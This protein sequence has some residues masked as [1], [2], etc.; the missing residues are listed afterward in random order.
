MEYALEVNNLWKEYEQF[1]L[2]S[3]DFKLEPGYIMGLIGPNG[4]GKTTLMRTILGIYEQNQ[5]EIKIF[6]KSLKDA[7]AQKDAKEMVGFV[8]EDNPFIEEFSCL[9]NGKIFG[10]YYLNWDQELFRS[11]LKRFEVDGKKKLSRLSK[12]MKIKFQLAFALSHNIKLLVMDEPSSGLDPVFRKELMEI[13]YDLIME[14]ER[15]ILFSTHLTEELDK[16]ADYITFLNQGKQ[17]FSMSKEEIAQRYR[18]V[19]GSETA[20]NSLNGADIIGKRKGAY[21]SEALVNYNIKEDYSKLQTEE[22]DIEDI[23]YYISEQGRG[24][25]NV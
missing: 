7:R 12:G 11:Y 1:Q 21:Y 3:V 25:R 9:E 20:V 23:M 18:L 19:K 2:E 17:I 5:G 15:S 6:G 13:M 8:L 22:P 24:W 4:S 14:G 16:V 10:G